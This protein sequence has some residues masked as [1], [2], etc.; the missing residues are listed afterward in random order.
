M[1]AQ[2]NDDGAI[3]GS[4]GL[5]IPATIET[6]PTGGPPGGS[7]YRTRAAEFG[8]SWVRPYPITVIAGG[9]QQLRG[10]VG[11]D[12][13][14]RNQLWRRGVGKALQ[15][16]TVQGDLGMKIEPSSSQSPERILRR[17]GRVGEVL[18]SHEL[19]ALLD[20]PEIRERLEFAAQCVRGRNQGDLDPS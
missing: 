19:G 8:E 1:P 15:V 7:G 9:H 11:T 10:N 3:Q 14:C 12:A 13:K 5:S 17:D 20:Q 18:G 2:P 16:P 4:V 6:V